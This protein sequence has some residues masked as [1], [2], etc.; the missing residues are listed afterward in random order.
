[1]AY[2]QLGQTDDA[3]ACFV[4]GKSE[5]DQ[6]G[7]GLTS[8]VL[9]EAANLLGM[10]LDEPPSTQE[11]IAAYRATLATDPAGAIRQNELAWLLATTPDVQYREPAQA[12]QHGLEAVRL[13]PQDA[14]AWNTLGVAH[15]R[16]GQWNEAIDAL[17]KSMERSGGTAI[18]WLF[19]AMTHWQRGERDEA[20]TWYDRAAT[21]MQDQA[22]EA[23]TEELTRFR[24]EADELLGTE[25]AAREQFNVG[26][27]E[28][29]AADAPIGNV[30]AIPPNQP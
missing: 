29:S 1:M 10:N 16:N 3:R 21:W 25:K 14:D 6:S 7:R 27:H 8:D 22:D 24:A 20:R 26:D 4:V 23:L 5:F 18:D 2:W 15:Y 17:N 12:V 19:L 30:P 9:Q 13:M 28:G 11:T